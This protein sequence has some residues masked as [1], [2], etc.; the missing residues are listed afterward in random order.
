[1][2][3]Y[4]GSKAWRLQGEVV[5]V[6]KKKPEEWTSADKLTVVTET[7]DLDAT[8]L[9]ACCQSEVPSI[10][11]WSIGAKQPRMTMKTST[12][13]VDAI[14]RACRAV[15]AKGAQDAPRLGP[16]GNQIIENTLQIK[17]VRTWFFRHAERILLI[18]R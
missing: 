9:S 12:H 2:T 4:K 15:R 14:R 16:E 1:M 6:S 10:S 8:E 7:A 18:G 5:A 17:V 11:S 3:R 13:H